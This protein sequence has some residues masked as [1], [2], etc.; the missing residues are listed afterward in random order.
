MTTYIIMSNGKAKSWHNKLKNANKE[1]KT[2]AIQTGSGHEILRSLHV[3]EGGTG[4]L[5]R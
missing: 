2:R 5:L 1:A 4:K 3:F